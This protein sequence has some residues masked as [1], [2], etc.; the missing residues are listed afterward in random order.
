MRLESAGCDFQ[1]RRAQPVG[2]IL[3]KPV[4]RFRRSRIREGGPIAFAAVGVQSELGNHQD[5]AAAV[6][7][8]PV[9]LALFVF[10]DAEIFNFIGKGG[11]IIR[12]ILL[13]DAQENAQSWADPTDG[14]LCHGDV[15]FG[16]SLHDGAHGDSTGSQA[17]G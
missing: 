15:G 6:D 5:L 3:I 14:L 7:D 1:A 12:T 10:E 9:H 16:D 4:G 17:G 11:G 2:K 13:P 8:R